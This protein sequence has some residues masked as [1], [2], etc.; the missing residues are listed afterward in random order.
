MT[1]VRCSVL[2]LCTFALPGSAGAQTCLGVPVHALAAADARVL[3]AEEWVGAGARAV[4]AS[5]RSLRIGVDGELLRHDNGANGAQATAMVG[6]E[7]GSRN[8]ICAYASGSLF[9]RDAIPDGGEGDM[10]GRSAGLGVGLGHWIV[11]RNLDVLLHGA[12]E[13]LVMRRNRTGDGALVVVVGGGLA[14]RRW[15]VGAAWKS[16][17]PYDV[18]LARNRGAGRVLLH[19]SADIGK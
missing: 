14:L 4:I 19:V 16:S 9:R 11:G 2:L 13:G 3:L 6:L 17:T 15:F 12:G 8:V 18:L 1:R 10:T 5:G 7:N